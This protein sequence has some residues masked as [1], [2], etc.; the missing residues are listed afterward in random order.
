MNL[1]LP[2]AIPLLFALCACPPKGPPPPRPDVSIRGK[3]SA[4]QPE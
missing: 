4:D 2:L 1:G 3:I